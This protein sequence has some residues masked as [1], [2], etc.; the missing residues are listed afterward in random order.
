MKFLMKADASLSKTSLMRQESHLHHSE[1][2]KIWTCH[3]ACALS[4]DSWA[5]A[6]LCHVRQDLQGILL[7]KGHH[8]WWNWSWHWRGWYLMNSSNS[9]AITGCNCRVQHR[10]LT[11]ASSNGAITGL[12]AS[13]WRDLLQR[14]QHGIE[15]KGS[16]HRKNIQ[17]RNYLITPHKPICTCQLFYWNIKIPGLHKKVTAMKCWSSHMWWVLNIKLY[18]HVLQ[19]EKCIQNF[20]GYVKQCMWI[21]I[22]I[23]KFQI[24]P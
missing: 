5:K 17:F 18:H 11:N 16:Y 20:N 4:A 15:V 23:T 3:K 21:I 1:G 10:G 22:T 14:G 9:R 13:S 12:A 6:G 24:W 2:H 19:S 8:N 7:F